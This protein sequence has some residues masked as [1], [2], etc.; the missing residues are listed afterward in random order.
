MMFL[1]FSAKYLSI[2]NKEIEQKLLS[3][4][5]RFTGWL[6]WYKIINISRPWEV[7]VLLISIVWGTCMGL[8]TGSIH[9]VF[10]LEQLGRRAK[11]FK[12]P[13][14]SKSIVWEVIELYTYLQEIL[15]K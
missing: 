14:N 13:G 1:A 3:H 8:T 4:N 11:L 10:V 7:V 9:T 5:Y 2:L 6:A 15:R 12:S